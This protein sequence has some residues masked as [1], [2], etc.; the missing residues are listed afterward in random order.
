MACRLT[1]TV[2]AMLASLSVAGCTYLEGSL[3]FHPVKTSPDDSKPPPP[4][5]EDVT[6]RTADGLKVHARWCPNPAASGAVLYCPG[7]A[8]NLEGRARPV[9]EL[10]QALGESVLIFD[11]PGYG[12]SEG[13]P[14]E[15]GCYAAADAAYLW[16]VESQHIPP[17][18][19]ILYG[20]SL[21]GGV[22]VEQASRRPHR[23]LVLVRTFASIPAVANARIASSA[24]SLVTNRFES[25]ARLGK[26]TQ[27]A[28]IAQADRD[29]VI[30]F[31]HGEHLRSACGGPTELFTLHGLDHN[32]PLPETFYQRLQEFLRTRAPLAQ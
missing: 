6:L 13:R 14:S 1:T 15:A 24:G 17:D 5:I 26:C 11:Y 27:P 30:P 18:R 32:D 4:P 28:F 31:A 29:R 22:A 23:A 21:G 16:L 9:H 3:L 20:E 7:N 12:R 8:G 25:V 2:L 10:Y 19:I